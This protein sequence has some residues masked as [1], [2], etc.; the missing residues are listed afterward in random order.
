MNDPPIPWPL[1]SVSS[2]SPRPSRA[3]THGD[4]PHFGIARMAARPATASHTLPGYG[5]S[6]FWLGQLFLRMAFQF[7]GSLLFTAPTRLF[8]FPHA[9]GTTLPGSLPPLF[10][11]H[12]PM[13]KPQPG[14]T[15]VSHFLGLAIGPLR[16]AQHVPYHTDASMRIDA[17]MLGSVLNFNGALATV[18]NPLLP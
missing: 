2:S 3:L 10:S 12:M 7:L 18:K 11:C 4:S 13:A 8:F 6:V 14:G 9:T 16:A 15:L 5:P 1:N 17:T